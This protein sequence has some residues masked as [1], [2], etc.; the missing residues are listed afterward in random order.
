VAR[1]DCVVLLT[2]HPGTDVRML[3]RTAVLLFDSRGAT[4]GMDAPNVVRL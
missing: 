4:V 2:T 3:V 1:Q